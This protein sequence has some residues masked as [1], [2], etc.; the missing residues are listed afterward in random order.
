MS[1]FWKY[2][3]LQKRSIPADP[4][5]VLEETKHRSNHFARY[6]LFLCR[7]STRVAEFF[8]FLFPSSTW[9]PL[10]WLLSSMSGELPWP[11]PQ[12]P[13]RHDMANVWGCRAI[14]WLNEWKLFKKYVII[15]TSRKERR[16]QK[17]C[18]RTFELLPNRQ[19]APP[20]RFE[21]VELNDFIQISACACIVGSMFQRWLFLIQKLNGF[22]KTRCV[23]SVSEPDFFAPGGISQNALQ[24]F[25][26][27]CCR[28]D[29]RWNH[30]NKT[31]RS[32]YFIMPKFVES[33]RL[34]PFQDSFDASEFLWALRARFSK[35][36]RSTGDEETVFY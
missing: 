23:T 17:L 14:S 8:E 32:I 3:F 34:R 28:L 15:R 1:T 20:Q 12:S 13:F 30:R 6:L 31:E 2:S 10:L 29:I 9:S 36:W 33:M 24:A 7:R 22:G 4:V 27:Y 18:K 26:S 11:C 35:P 21:T 19:C 5:T 16:I 25:K